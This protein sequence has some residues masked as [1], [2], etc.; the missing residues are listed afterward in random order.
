MITVHETALAG[1]VI[2]EPRV[3]GDHRGFFQ[4]TWRADSYS[5]LGIPEF[6]QDNHS[7]SSY[8]VLRGLHSQRQRPQGKLVRVASGRVLDVAADVNPN[9]PTFGQHVAV[10][11]DDQSGR[12][13]YIPPGYVHGFC[14]LSE[15]ADFIYRCTDY[16]QP[17]DEIG[18]RW[19]DPDLNI[20]WPDIS[21]LLSDKDL[22][23]PS[24]KQLAEQWT[25]EQW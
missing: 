7:R 17:G 20:Q 10:E 18:V 22:A 23:L 9:S 25:R 21:P 14:V 12:Q 16:Y 3:F 15:S 6:V 5:A 8:G 1:V 4:E 24:L 2:I 19:D 11:L 13:L